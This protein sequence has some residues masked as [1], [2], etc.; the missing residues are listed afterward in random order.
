MAEL[1]ADTTDSFLAALLNFRQRKSLKYNSIY[2]QM[3]N[4]VSRMNG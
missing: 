1:P 4:V 3:E 2:A